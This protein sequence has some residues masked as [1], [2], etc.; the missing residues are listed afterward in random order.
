MDDIEELLEEELEKAGGPPKPAVNSPV[1]SP[2]TPGHVA[3]HGAPAPAPE[4]AEPA[5]PASAAVQPSEL[6]TSK[7]HKRQWNQLQRV[8]C[9][10]RASAFP[11]LSSMWGG[12]VMEKRQALQQFLQSGENLEA[13]E[14]TMLYS[15][16]KKDR[17]EHNVDG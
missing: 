10:P 9:G 14:A 16:R 12:S 5:P 1:P 4:P 6:P 7:S 3:A 17:M 11:T 15:R 8:A 2:S 13:T